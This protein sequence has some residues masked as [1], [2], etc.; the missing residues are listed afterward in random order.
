ADTQVKEGDRGQTNARFVVTLDNPSPE[1]V[2][3]NYATA[4]GTATVRDRDY[5]RTS[6][7][8]VFRP[9]QTRQF[10]DV[11]VF[12][13]TKIEP[14]ETFTVNLSNPQ[15]AELGRR[16]ATGTILNDDFPQI[17]IRDTEITEGDRGQTNARFLVTL[18]SPSPER[19][20][21]NYATADGTATA[22]E[23]YRRTTGRL[24]F[25]PGQT[26]QFIDV[27]VFGD[28]E[29]EPDETFTVNLSRPQNAQLGRRQATGT[30][31]NDDGSSPAVNLG[32][33]TGEPIVINDEIGF[34]EAGD[35]NTE[36]YYRF[37]LNRE[38]TVRIILDELFENANLEFLGSTR[39]MI[40]QSR[41][42]GTQREIITQRNLEPGTYYVR[43][44][45]HLAART[46]YRLSIN[47]I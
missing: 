30:I 11:P 1:R 22:G 35:R 19:V 5:R 10:I 13:D 33:L 2:T 23:D 16:R 44:F 34:T 43:V 32:R 9:G 25:R 7:R 41:N 31:I 47:L 46:E 21:V 20:V 27:P 6:G 28:T 29:I 8:L 15:N 39:E 18:D 3:V 17:S 45:P 4:D 37:N 40:D 12:G 38:G 42:P 14:D 26:R 36:D 24:I